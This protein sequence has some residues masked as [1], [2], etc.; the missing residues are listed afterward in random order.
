MARKPVRPDER[1]EKTRARVADYAARKRKAGFRQY[2]FWL[3][4]GEAK[5]VRALIKQ[6]REKEK[7]E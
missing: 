6:L 2:A 3:R 7:E 4:P 5:A 1:A